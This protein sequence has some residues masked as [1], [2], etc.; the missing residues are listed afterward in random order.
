MALDKIV[1]QLLKNASSVISIKKTAFIHLASTLDAIS[2]LKVLGRG[3]SIA[4]DM[5]GYVIKSVEDVSM[6]ERIRLKLNEGSLQCI[7][8]A[9]LS[10][11]KEYSNDRNEF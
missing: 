2:P 3:Y 8:D 4:T 6:G 11:G 1:A 9:V 10:E 7:I 5:D